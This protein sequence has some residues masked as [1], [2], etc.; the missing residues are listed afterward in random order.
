MASLP[1]NLA[2]WCC[3]RPVLGRKVPGHADN[4]ETPPP[5][6]ATP[7]LF[8]TECSYLGKGQNELLLTPEG[9]F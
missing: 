5:R 3:W 2:A 9:L 1:G 6:A 8:L 7:A 4:L